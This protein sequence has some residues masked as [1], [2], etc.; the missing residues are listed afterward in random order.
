MQRLAL[1]MEEYSRASQEEPCFI[2]RIIDGT[3]AVSHEVVHRDDFAIAFLNRYPTLYGYCLVA[4]IEHRVE[5]VGDFD[6][7]DYL[8]LQSIVRRVAGAVSAVVPTERMY[9][10][11]LGSNQGNDHVH[12]HVAPLPPGVP[13]EEQQLRALMV[14]TSGYI[15]LD[16]DHQHQLADDLRRA[17]GEQGGGQE[18]ARIDP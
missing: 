17:L 6:E 10:L 9:V 4:P 2:C 8:R 12:W 5:V 7:R 14:E 3:H 13:Y 1:D 18:P 16:A 11:S 15:Q